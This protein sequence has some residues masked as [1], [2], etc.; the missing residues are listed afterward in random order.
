M[1]QGSKKLGSD[2]S[3]ES[4][5][6]D[7]LAKQGRLAPVPVFFAMALVSSFVADDLH[8]VWWMGWLC[9]VGFMLFARMFTFNRLRNLHQ[10]SVKNRLR[11]SVIL[12]V[13]NGMTH[14]SILFAFPLMSE[15][16]R[17]TLSLFL[18]GTS[19]I[20]VISIAGFLPMTIA[21]MTPT[22]VPISVLWAINP[23]YGANATSM[24]IA[25]M[26]FLYIPIL[27]KT[28]RETFQT[29][30][31][32]IER[33]QQEIFLNQKLEEALDRARIANQ[34]KT[35]FLAA[36]S[37]DLRQP[38]HTLSL[39]SAA[40]SGRK[41][42]E[43][44]K[45]ISGNMEIAIQNMANQLDSLLDISKLDA[46][47]IPVNDSNLRLDRLIQRLGKELSS[48]AEEKNLSLECITSETSYVYT[49]EI[50]LERVLRNIMGNAI[51]Y[52]ER[53]GIKIRLQNRFSQYCI[54]IEDTGP[55]IPKEEQET[56]FEEFYQLDNPERNRSKG[57]GL[58][59]AIVKRLVDLL[60]LQMTLKSE[61][62]KGS[63]FEIFIDKASSDSAADI[64]VEKSNFFDWSKLTILV[65]DNEI[66]VLN[67]MQELLEIMGAQV[68]LANNGT[69]A[70]AMSRETQPSIML[71]DF[72][73][74]NDENGLDVIKNIHHEY[75]GLPA[76]IISGGINKREKKKVMQHGIPLL[77][78]PVPVE[79]LRDAISS[80]CT[81]Q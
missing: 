70:L 31:D 63:R 22:M 19:A 4:A 37:H 45:E 52:T 71:V 33:R 8:P 20:N 76:I 24:G 1:T 56:I 54:I 79:K 39:Y 16:E 46:G 7:M 68:M 27:I 61:P 11:F 47:V 29:F 75:P 44:S 80:H 35:R 67:A 13:V 10:F 78:K 41:L 18:V 59:L 50:L 2:D 17:A 32:S 55:G 34:S 49:D 66:Q 9:M 38:I 60:R 6:L 30:K 43:K 64:S 73:L 25:I 12:S 26:H 15:F 21:Y 14:G 5:M 74:A 69:V 53:G 42:D 23:G 36:A 65:V 57:L 58:G 51:K 77:M 3:V 48:T 62:G 40:L 72:Q 28:G 81:S